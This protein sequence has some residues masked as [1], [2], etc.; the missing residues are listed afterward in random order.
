MSRPSSPRA[1]SPIVSLT[2]WISSKV[3]SGPSKSGLRRL[4]RRCSFRAVATRTPSS[5]RARGEQLVEHREDILRR[6]HAPHGEILARARDLL[7]ALPHGCFYAVVIA[8]AVCRLYVGEVL[9][10]GQDLLVQ[11]LEAARHVVVEVV[12]VGGL[13]RVDVP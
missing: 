9:A 6:R 12:A 8:L 11:Q 13:R 7:V 5:R 1:M 4:L 2:F 3:H 10:D